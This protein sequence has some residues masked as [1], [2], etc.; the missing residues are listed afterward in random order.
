MKKT[1]RILRNQ[2][3]IQILK[4][5]LRNPLMWIFFKKALER[6]IFELESQNYRLLKN[7]ESDI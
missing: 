2:M 4:K 5:Q 7:L 6:E 1:D 3:Q